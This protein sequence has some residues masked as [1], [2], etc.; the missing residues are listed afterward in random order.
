[1][2]D[3]SSCVLK[4]VFK[5]WSRE[6]S[7]PE[8][9]NHGFENMESIGTTVYSF[10]VNYIFVLLSSGCRKQY[11]NT[12]FEGAVYSRISSQILGDWNACGKVMGLAAWADKKKSAA[13]DWIFSKQNINGLSLGDDFYHKVNLMSGTVLVII[14]RFHSFLFFKLVIE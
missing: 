2:F 6:R 3:R 13:R 5:R 10:Q 9:Y 4:P 1:M 8:L 7:P 11:T 12:F 14:F